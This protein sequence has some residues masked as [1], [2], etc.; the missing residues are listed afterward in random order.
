MIG[1]LI[2]I[3]VEELPTRRARKKPFFRRT[4]F[5]ATLLL[6]AVLGLAGYVGLQLYLKSFRE[7]AASYDLT[8]LGKLEESS[9]A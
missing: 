9:I 1:D 6:I 8:Q 5:K 3:K 7:R 4:W 2:K